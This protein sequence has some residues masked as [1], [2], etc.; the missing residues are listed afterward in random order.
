MISMVAPKYSPSTAV[1][2]WTSFRQHGNSFRQGFERWY[3]R[4]EFGFQNPPLKAS[5]G[6]SGRSKIRGETKIT[7]VG[8]D[9]R[10]KRGKARTLDH[11]YIVL[12]T[13]AR[14]D[15]TEK[16]QR[17]ENKVDDLNVMVHK[18]RL[19]KMVRHR[20]MRGTK[21]VKEARKPVNSGLF[22]SSSISWRKH[23]IH[24]TLVAPILS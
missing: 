1:T 4:R 6:C 17:W 19:R 21:E 7:G 15:N 11:Y 8:T 3:R 9:S 5:A 14:A 10:Q 22:I 23:P 13:A 12:D 20:N 2:S 16:N 18:Y 24:P